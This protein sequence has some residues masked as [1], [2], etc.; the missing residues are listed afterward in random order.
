MPCPEPAGKDFPVSEKKI[1]RRSMRITVFACCPFC[2]SGKVTKY[3]KEKNGAQRF[4]CASCGRT[5]TGRENTVL[6]SSKVSPGHIRRMLSMLME[7][8]TI[9]QACHQSKVSLRT[10]VLYLRKFQALISPGS[11]HFMGW[12]GWADETYASAPMKEQKPG[13][14]VSVLT[15][16]RKKKA[17]LSRNLIP[18]FCGV[19]DEGRC[20]AEVGDGRGVPGV[21]ECRK[22][23]QGKFR[24]GSTITHDSGNYGDI[25]AG[26]K[27]IETDS[28]SAEAHDL[29]NPINRFTNLIQRCFKVHLRIRRKNIQKWLNVVCFMYENHLETFDELWDWVSVRIFFSGKTLRRKDI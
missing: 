2:G 22:H 15:G 6:F 28:D 18:I 27:E 11:H 19:D 14:G 9:R 17:G 1:D 12:N 21:E 13:K 26:C 29:L 8:T 4:R 7:G 25:F 16:R 3:G 10:G 5:F 20:F 23:Y 24:P